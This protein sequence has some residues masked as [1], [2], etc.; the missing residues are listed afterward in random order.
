MDPML[1]RFPG[2][3]A[4]RVL[5]I[6]E[7]DP[8]EFEP[9]GPTAMPQPSVEPTAAP[10]APQA[11]TGP[12]TLAPTQRLNNV[13]ENGGCSPHETLH[14]I[15]MFDL[16]GDGWGGSN[17]ILTRM[18]N[19]GEAPGVQTLQGRPDGS[20]QISEVVQV[21]VTSFE[22]YSVPK[23]VFSGTM[24]D[25]SE[26][27]EYVCLEQDRCY[28]VQINASD[29]DWEIK[30]EVR[31][32]SL[33]AEKETWDD[34]F[35]VGLAPTVCHFSLPGSTGDGA[36]PD[37]CGERSSRDFDSTPRDVTLPTPS[38]S[39]APQ[40]T[41]A[42]T[43]FMPSDAPSL[44]P[45]GQPQASLLETDGGSTTPPSDAPSFVPTNRI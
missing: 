40:N 4:N 44:V 18:V 27:F 11:P 24:S 14:E 6:Q 8:F 39:L 15:K 33:G 43:T 10:F 23:K 9:M 16:W 21:G 31:K 20:N 28:E 34:S 36:C 19:P 30:W 13:Q 3:D 41:G 5:F 25:G 2:F 42:T 7:S 38:P 37:T 22:D 26:H 35:T 12:P 17:L 29:F 1:Y 45:S 32:V